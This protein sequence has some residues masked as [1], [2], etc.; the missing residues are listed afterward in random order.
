RVRVRVVGV[1]RERR[2]KERVCAEQRIAQAVGG[3]LLSI[4]A[5]GAAEEAE[6]IRLVEP[7]ATVARRHGPAVAVHDLA[8]APG[9]VA[10]TE[11]PGAVVLRAPEVAAVVAVG[12]APIELRAAE[13]LVH[14]GPAGAEQRILRLV[15]I[16]GAIEAAIAA[17]IHAPPAV[18]VVG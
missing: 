13:A 2:D 12:G 11:P 4:A 9:P 14:L 17:E 5:I 6:I 18:V 3:L 7:M 16:V 1:H 10:V 15:D 8:P